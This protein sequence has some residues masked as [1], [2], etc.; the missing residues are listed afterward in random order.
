[1]KLNQLINEVRKELL[2]STTSTTTEEMYPFLFV[3]EIEIEVAV[4]ITQDA[5]LNSS[6]SVKVL[7]IGAEVGGELSK[8]DAQQNRIKIKMTPL[9]S[10]E[11]I[12]EK[13][14]ADNP[15]IWD[16]VMNTAKRGTSK[17]F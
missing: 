16:K 3:D 17:S 2:T 15:Q 14:K 1:M 12:R 4:E 7:D 13:L 11:E 9:F 6:I 5:N 10:K 8:S